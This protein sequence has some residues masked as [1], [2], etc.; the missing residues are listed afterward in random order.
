MNVILILIGFVAG[1][2]TCAGI[3]WAVLC[4]EKKQE[5]RYMDGVVRNFNRRKHES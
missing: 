3:V 2:G 1:F 5:D 4:R